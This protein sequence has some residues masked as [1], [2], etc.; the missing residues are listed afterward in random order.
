MKPREEQ[1]KENNECDVFEP[2]LGWGLETGAETTECE[3]T[4]EFAVK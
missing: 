2:G 3:T 4:D 1:T